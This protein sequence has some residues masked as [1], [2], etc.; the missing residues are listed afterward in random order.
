MVRKGA[1]AAGF[2]AISEADSMCDA[3]QIARSKA[4]AGDVVVLTPGLASFDMFKNFEHRGQ[5]FKEI[6]LDMERAAK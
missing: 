6:V 3:V 1:E 2:V 4:T 5:V